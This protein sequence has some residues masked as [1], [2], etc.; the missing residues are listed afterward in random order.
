MD[1]RDV[2]IL[3][4]VFN[5]EKHLR[6]SIDS[7]LNQTYSFLEI[8]IINDGSNDQSEDIIQSYSDPR[9][10]YIKNNENKGLI[11]TL[12]IGFSL[13]TGKYI[14]RMDADDIAM[15]LRI[16]KQ[17]R[18]MEENSQIGIVGT[19]YTIFGDKNET[20]H[21]P[22]KQDDIKLACLFYNPF[23]HPSVMIR[24]DII[25][26]NNLLFR[27]EYLHAEEY[28]LWTEILTITEGYNIQEELLKYRSHTSQISQ[29]HLKQQLENSKIIQK[30]YLEKGGFRLTANDL[31][32]IWDDHSFSSLKD[33]M[34]KMIGLQKLIDQNKKIHFFDSNNWKRILSTRYKNLLLELKGMNREIYQ[35]Y[36]MSQISKEIDW[37]I[38]QKISLFLKFFLKR[39]SRIKE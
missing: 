4:P 10:R 5:A 16:E 28:K 18:F 34:D 7:I 13:A 9:I 29:V 37:T 39:E 14:A 6:E 21:Y 36:K 26:T 32:A 20:V 35:H 27:K 8:L 3:L 12:N 17:V 11:E 2:T 23:C 24:K 25:D 22:E 15:P 38:K 30:E 1:N 33:V 31:K 19:S